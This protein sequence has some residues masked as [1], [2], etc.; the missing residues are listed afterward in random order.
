[1]EIKYPEIRVT[2]TGK[3]GNAYSILAA[4]ARALRIENIP[5]KEIEAFHLEATSGDYDHLL[6][7]AMKWVD[8]N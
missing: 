3:D 6:Q 5:K 4:V 7:T 8:V 1:M 2:L